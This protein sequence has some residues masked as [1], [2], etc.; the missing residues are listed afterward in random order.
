[1]SPLGAHTPHTGFT[2]S[3]FTRRDRHVAHAST[4]DSEKHGRETAGD[5]RYRECTRRC[6]STGNSTGN[7]TGFAARCATGLGPRLYISN[8]ENDITSISGIKRIVSHE[9]SSGLSSGWL[10]AVCQTKGYHTSHHLM[11]RRMHTISLDNIANQGSFASSH[12]RRSP[13]SI[14]V[15]SRCATF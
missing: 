10:C 1:M 4:T 3:H 8:S 11:Q 13:T 12:S 14:V 2:A 7:S 9:I 15:C 5:T 6:K